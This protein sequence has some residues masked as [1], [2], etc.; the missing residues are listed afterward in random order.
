MRL[1]LC[2]MLI[3]PTVSLYAAGSTGWPQQIQRGVNVSTDITAQDLAHLADDW[4]A[5]SVR[6]LVNNITAESPPYQVSARK[7]K[8]VFDCID[9]CLGQGF[10]TVFSPSASFRNN[11]RFFGS[12]A[13]KAAYLEFWQEVA[14][15]YAGSGGI[16]YD[17]MNEPHDNLADLHWS[18]Y[19]GE[20]TA[21]IRAIDSV[22]TIVVEPPGW[23]WP[24]GFDHLVP[25]GDR[26]TVYSFHF[27]GPMDYTHQRNRGHMRTTEEQCRQ[28]AYPGDIEGEYWDK[29]KI[30]S[31]IQQ[32]F[33][34]RDS[35]KVR[36][37]CG[38]FG[39]AR[40]AVGA[41]LWL[42]DLIDILEEEKVGWSYYAYREWHHMDLEMDPAERVEKTERTETEL[43][44]LFKGYF[45]GNE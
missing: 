10:Y 36:I 38:E 4:K 13:W 33:E 40:W 9:L 3:L 37:W 31:S 21:A 19:A 39:V 30:R 22:H 44:K 12:E 7:K 26:N 20:L 2:L 45:A 41:K 6:I 17:L 35:H 18:Q 24:A 29:E 43:V 25:T 5:N 8:E 1:T 14:T 34:F 15:R 42:G 28:R 11:D 27:Y 23:G 16:A 32:A